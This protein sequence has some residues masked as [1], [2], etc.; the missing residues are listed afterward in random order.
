MTSPADAGGQPSGIVELTTTPF[1]AQRQ[2]QCGPAALATVLAASAVDVT[3]DELTPLMYLPGRR[4]SLQT[5]LVAAA[6]RYERVPY[7]LLPSLDAL[8]G[9][10]A[11]GRPVLVLQ[12]FGAGPVPGWHY[13]VV[14]GYDS[15]SDRIVLRSG[16]RKR[17]EMPADRFLASWN[18]ADRWALAILKPGEMPDKPDIQRYMQAAAGLEAVGQYAAASLAYEAAT[19]QWPDASLPRLGI[20]NLAYMQGDFRAA[21]RGYLAA[22]ARSP[23]DVVARNN[24]AEVL[25]QLGCPATAADEIEVA[26]VLAAG[27]PFAAMIASSA[28]RIGAASGVDSPG[29]PTATVVAARHTD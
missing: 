20:G 23:S 3:P 28:S 18:R 11:A 16:T 15:K 4:G 27:G 5:E 7:L 22:I 6:R 8:L 9:E 24:R 25:L 21:E 26:R 29:C 14:I 19:R 13:A 10:V 2:Y 17:L 12:K 1:F